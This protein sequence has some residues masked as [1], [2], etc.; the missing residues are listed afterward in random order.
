M[1]SK[2][3]KKKRLPSLI[4][5]IL[6]IGL[7]II[8]LFL[9]ISAD[10]L[11]SIGYILLSVV[12]LMVGSIIL[13]IRYFMAPIPAAPPTKPEKTGSSS[14]SPLVTARP[15]PKGT[16][17]RVDP[18]AVCSKSP[19]LPLSS[20]I[21]LDVE[22]TGLSPE[23][24]HII[25]FGAIKV[26]NGEEIA[27]FQTF[28]DPGCPV[29]RR[30]TEITGITNADLAGAPSLLPA[31]HMISDFIGDVP[32]VAHNA[33]FDLG[34]LRNAYA[35]AG[36]PVRFDVIDTLRLARASFPDA[37]NHK[38][39]T[40]IDYLHLGGTQSHRALSDVHYTNLIYQAC[41]NAETRNNL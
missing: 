36:L 10:I 19:Q 21:V 12:L 8:S 39:S 13:I 35:A 33:S 17:V 9:S 34:F 24:D 11:S 16:V 7:G 40:L 26:E 15:V 31:I 37:P 28:I 25:E 3:P 1:G 38:L 27:S 20:Y 4:I 32:I 18:R 22:T 30:I 14:Q 2:P 5:G 6:T 23:R 29:P 41:M